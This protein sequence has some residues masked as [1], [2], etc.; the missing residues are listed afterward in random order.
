M[1]NTNE[2]TQLA[3]IQLPI[4]TQLDDSDVSI[5][6]KPGDT[7]GMYYCS[8]TSVTSLKF[9]FLAVIVGLF[10]MDQAQLKSALLT[11]THPCWG[12][13]EP[14]SLSCLFQRDE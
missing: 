8:T 11:A 7:A 6:R 13:M 12:I 10:R 4:A 1:S 2:G 3:H 5:F 9:G 14:S